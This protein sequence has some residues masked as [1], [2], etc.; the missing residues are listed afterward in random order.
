MATWIDLFSLL[1]TICVLGGIVYGIIYLVNTI[2]EGV[3]STKESLKS[4]GYNISSSGVSVKTTKRF[5]HEDEVDAHQRGIMKVMG[6]ASFRKG[7]APQAPQM[8]SSW[9]KDS[10]SSIKSDKSSGGPEEK[11]K[12]KKRNI[13]RR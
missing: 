8:D 7:E 13:F 3:N 1:A 12:K 4:K 10:A 11:E 6:A 5:N 9:S 2:N